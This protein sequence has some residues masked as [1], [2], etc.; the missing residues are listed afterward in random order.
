MYHQD[1][2][3]DLDL[4]H[5]NKFGF[6]EYGKTRWNNFSDQKKKQ[7]IKSL[8][9]NINI[10]KRLKISG[11]LD[12]KIAFN[13]FISLDNQ[14]DILLKHLE[15]NFNKLVGN[16]F[17]LDS[18]MIIKLFEKFEDLNKIFKKKKFWIVLN[19]I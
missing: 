13:K 18:K 11:F 12:F 3:C 5:L 2:E 15:F 10:G 8:M 4:K 19:Q 14:I 6:N 16:N 17:D 1:P 7:E 9:Q